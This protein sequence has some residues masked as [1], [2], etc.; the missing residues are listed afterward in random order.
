MLSVYFLKTNVAVGQHYQEFYGNIAI[1]L[2]IAAFFKFKDVKF[3]FLDHILKIAKIFMCTPSNT[4]FITDR[5]NLIFNTFNTRP[6]PRAGG[7]WQPDDVR[8][9][10]PGP[11][12]HF[13]LPFLHL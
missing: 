13:M 7:S 11:G 9:P 2:K 5:F 10:P 12:G 1:I 8:T 4:I 3:G 6:S